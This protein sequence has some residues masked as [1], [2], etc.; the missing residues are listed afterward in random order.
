MATNSYELSLKFNDGRIE[1]VPHGKTSI[2]QPYKDTL[3]DFSRF[4]S[5]C[6]DRDNEYFNNLIAEVISEE[7]LDIIKSMDFV[8]EYFEYECYAPIIELGGSITSLSPITYN[9]KVKI[10]DASFSGD[11]FTIGEWTDKDEHPVHHYVDP[12]DFFDD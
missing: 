10:V 11:V 4:L 2:E 12:E 6:L 7:I 3:N 1:A 9:L 8:D 5:G